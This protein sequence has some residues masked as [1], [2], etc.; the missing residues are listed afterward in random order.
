MDLIPYGQAVT[1]A[2]LGSTDLVVAL[3]VADY[4][5]TEGD[6]AQDDEAWSQ[7]EIAALEAYVTNGGLLVLAKQRTSPEVHQHRDGSER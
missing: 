2:D 3:P 7:G 1:A 4:P 5:S 6:S